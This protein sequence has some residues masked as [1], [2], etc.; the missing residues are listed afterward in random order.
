MRKQRSYLARREI[1]FAPEEPRPGLNGR[2]IVAG[3]VAGGAVAIVIAFAA[4][5]RLVSALM[6]SDK[7]CME[8]AS[9]ADA[10]AYFAANGLG[11]ASEIQ[12]KDD[13]RVCAVLP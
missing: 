13:G 4:P 8:F 10:D 1:S 11:D 2:H 3:L 5:T 6:P 7:S 12:E 9:Q